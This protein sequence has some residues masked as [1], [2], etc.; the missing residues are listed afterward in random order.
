MYLDCMTYGYCQP[1]RLDSSGGKKKTCT[2][3]LLELSR[4]FYDICLLEGRKLSVLL[5]GV[6]IYFR[7]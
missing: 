2:N 4:L 7:D 6:F 5:V 1:S 3:F